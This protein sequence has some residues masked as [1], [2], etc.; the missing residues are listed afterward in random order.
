MEAGWLAGALWD[1]IAL[2]V[3]AV[4]LLVST[5]MLYSRSDAPPPVSIARLA[6]GYVVVVLMCCGFAAASSYTPAD[7][8]GA[9]WGIPPERYWSALLVEFS[10]LW[11]LLSY[12]VLV[13]MAIIGVPV[14]F[15]MARRGWGTVP[16]LMAISVP[17]SLLFLVAL[18]AL[19]R[20]AL[21]RRL[22]LDAALTILAMHLVLSLG[23]GVAAGLP[24]RRKT[25]PSRMSDS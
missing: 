18:T 23:F 4:I 24:W 25:P 9:R 7:E 5:A 14:L 20:R 11:V 21:S 19:S 2:A 22:A 12:G 6:L 8:A 16:G 10:T 13:G 17:I 1:P 15:A 3:L